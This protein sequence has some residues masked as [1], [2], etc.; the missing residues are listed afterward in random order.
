M[1]GTDLRSAKGASGATPRTVAK[2]AVDVGVRHQVRQPGETALRPQGR[3]GA[4]EPS[5]RCQRQRAANAD[6]SYSEPR[7]FSDIRANISN[8]Q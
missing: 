3:R 8:H 2:E 4:N 1:I 7:D 5:P 6:A